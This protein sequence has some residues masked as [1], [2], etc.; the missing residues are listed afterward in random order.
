MNLLVENYYFPKSVNQLP[1]LTLLKPPFLPIRP[2][3]FDLFDTQDDFDFIETLSSF[4]VYILFIN[5]H[6]HGTYIDSGIKF[7]VVKP[8]YLGNM[9]KI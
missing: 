1:E 9:L 6:K 8:F 7:N 4:S 2:G 3:L 5:F